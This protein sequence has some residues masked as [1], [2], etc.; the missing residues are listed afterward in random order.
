MIHRQ[1]LGTAAVDARAQPHH[2]V[3]CLGDIP[4]G[5][6]PLSHITHPL[7]ITAVS[8]R[9]GFTVSDQSLAT[10]AAARPSAALRHAGT[11]PL[12]LFPAI[13]ARHPIKITALRS[14]LP[15]TEDNEPPETQAGQVYHVAAPGFQEGLYSSD[16]HSRV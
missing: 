12:L 2:L 16:C 7:D 5:H 11:Q 15:L 4:G 1:L 3:Y 6:L 10:V 9:V 14:S 8:Q 13:T